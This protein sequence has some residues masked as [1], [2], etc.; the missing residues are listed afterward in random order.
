[1]K[2]VA[3][4]LKLKRCK[5][6]GSVLHNK[7]SEVK[8]I[9]GMPWRTA[10]RANRYRNRASHHKFGNDI[11]EEHDY[12]D[13]DEENENQNRDNDDDVD[14]VNE[15][16]LEKNSGYVTMASSS[17]YNSSNSNSNRNNSNNINNEQHKV[18]FHQSQMDH[19]KNDFLSNLDKIK[20]K[21]KNDF[22]NGF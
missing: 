1:M 18:H 17:N 10:A 5:S 13:N 12:E 14:D 2:Q 20:V 19:K 22:F 16:E 9:S 8:Q 11:E 21:K 6:T 15:T 7:S 4:A 3:N